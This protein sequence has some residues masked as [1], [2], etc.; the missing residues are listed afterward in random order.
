[1]KKSYYLLGIF[2]LIS[3][4]GN[5][6]SS[7]IFETDFASLPYNWYASTFAFGSSGAFIDQF[8]YTSYDANLCT[9]GMPVEYSIF[10][11][12][13]TDSVKV[14]VDYS[15]SASGGVGTV[16]EFEIYLGTSS[17]SLE[18]VWGVY[19]S[20]YNPQV[21]QSGVLIFTPSWIQAADF[22]GLLFRADITPYD[23]ANVSWYIHSLTI[24]AYGE[25]MDLE[26]S[27]WTD[28]KSTVPIE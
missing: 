14:E 16:M 5:A 21:Y 11:P 3:S 8:S 25:D 12:D 2:F 26:Q 15:L 19:P 23:G 6:G 17:H 13:G 9:G 28:I 20:Q 7:V 18:T 27:T 22:I 24:T 4:A 1:M 10:V